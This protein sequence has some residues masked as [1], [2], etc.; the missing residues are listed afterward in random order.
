MD[1]TV[2]LWDLREGRCERVLEEHLATVNSVAFS[3][4]GHWSLSGSEDH[5][6]NLWAL[7]W[8]LQ[9]HDAADWDEG[10]RLVLEAFLTQQ[11]PY[12]G[13]LPNDRAPT[14]SELRAA[15]SRGG[16]PRWNNR[17]FDKLLALLRYTGWGWL[18]PA[19]VRRTL[20]RSAQ[21]WTGPYTL[22]R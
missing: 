3:A 14:E 17:N 20:E 5:V 10:A 1:R 19:G 13:T 12:R 11:T 7:D 18:C 2:R 22:S 6:F 4:D 21:Q 15:L 8:T 9:A 16:R